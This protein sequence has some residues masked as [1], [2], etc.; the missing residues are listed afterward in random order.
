MSIIESLL[1][2]LIPSSKYPNYLRRKGVKIG[3]NC[4]IYKS[5]NFGSEPYLIEIGNHV[6]INSGVQLFTHDGGLWVLR[7][8]ISGYDQEFSDADIF[9]K[10]VIEDNVHIATNAIIMPG[11]HIGKNSIVGCGAVVTHD[12]QSGSVVAGVPARKIE[13]IQEYAD[14]CRD[15]ID[16]TKHLNATEKKKYILKKYNIKS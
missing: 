4:E 10:I 16:N 8:D 13:T 11:V 1:V 3:N 7:S 14:K 2:K 5:A 6:R 9:K 12:I 15:K